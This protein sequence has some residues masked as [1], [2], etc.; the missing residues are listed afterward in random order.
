MF[1]RVA[2]LVNQQ[3]WLQNLYMID[4]SIGIPCSGSTYLKIKL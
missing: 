1:P 3:V 2:I 4:F